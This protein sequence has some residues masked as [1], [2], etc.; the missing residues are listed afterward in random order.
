MNREKVFGLLIGFIG[1]VTLLA[2]GIGIGLNIAPKPITCEP[3]SYVSG[4]GCLIPPDYQLP[5][6]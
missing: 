2:L 1:S 4:E 6:E 5:T 3:P